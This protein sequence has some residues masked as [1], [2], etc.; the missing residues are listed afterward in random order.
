[1]QKNQTKGQMIS[2]ESEES[3]DYVRGLILN[4]DTT[5]EFS[6]NFLAERVIGSQSSNKIKIYIDQRFYNVKGC[7]FNFW[8]LLYKGYT[9]LAIQFYENESQ[10]LKRFINE[11]EKTL[12]E[13]FTKIKIRLHQDDPNL[14]RIVEELEGLKWG[15]QEAMSLGLDD[16]ATHMIKK[17]QAI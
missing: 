3:D 11:R 1:M 4:K 7:E 12:S 8:I 9:D 2:E 13:G 17:H 15:I 6:T 16:F 14:R 5:Y 10:T